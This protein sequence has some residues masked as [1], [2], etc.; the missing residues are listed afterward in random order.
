[1]IME[2]NMKK[3]LK[4]LGLAH[5]PVRHIPLSDADSQSDDLFVVG[6]DIAPAM[7]DFKRVVVMHNLVSREEFTEKIKRALA[8]TE[9]RFRIE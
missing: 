4:T 5:I 3:V 6:L 2:M 9:K 1:M 8:C 7:R